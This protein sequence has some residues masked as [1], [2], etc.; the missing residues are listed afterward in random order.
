VFITAIWLG[1]VRWSFV[2][3]R[4]AFG[5]FRRARDDITAWYRAIILLEIAYW[6]AIRTLTEHHLC[7][8][9]RESCPSNIAYTIITSAYSQRFWTAHSYVARIEL[10][11]W[12]SHPPYV[13]SRHD[14]R[15]GNLLVVVRGIYAGKL[16]KCLLMVISKMFCR[17]TVLYSS[18]MIS[19][20]T[21]TQTEV[22]QAGTK[23]A[24]D[25]NSP[26]WHHLLQI[27][28]FSVWNCLLVSLEVT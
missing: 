28:G 19:N 21:P 27:I 2:N 23:M 3:V 13:N 26:R 6:S 9:Y 15:A 14:N 20:G 24:Q 8:K 17:S 18:V 11:T 22:N 16:I 4:K 1:Q 7:W 10:Q 12:W 25:K 5:S